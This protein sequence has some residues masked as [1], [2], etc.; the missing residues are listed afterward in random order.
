MCSKIIPS[1]YSLGTVIF[2]MW[3][4]NYL[5]Y[6]SRRFLK[7]RLKNQSL[8]DQDG[9]VQ[10]YSCTV[11]TNSITDSDCWNSLFYNTR[12]KEIKPVP[13]WS[14][15]SAATLWRKIVFS[16]FEINVA[17]FQIWTPGAAPDARDIPHAAARVGAVHQTAATG[18]DRLVPGQGDRTAPYRRRHRGRTSAAR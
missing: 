2:E 15:L 11:Y 16:P 8:Q 13:H 9:S 12:K 7:P 10:I 4:R 18:P 3:S 6:S 1:K 14:Y 5:K 17:W